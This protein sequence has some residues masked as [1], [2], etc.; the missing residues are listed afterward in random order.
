MTTDEKRKLI[1]AG[2]LMFLFLLLPKQLTDL[3]SAITN[4]LK[5]FLPPLE[6]FST[7]PYWDHK[8]WSWG[9]GTR[10]PGSTNDPAI[11]PGGTITREKAF[12]DM[13]KYLQND[14]M[15]LLPL[16]VPRLNAKQWTA[17]LSFSYNLGIGNAKNLLDNI[18]KQD[19]AALELQWKKY[20]YASGVINSTLVARRNKEWQLWIS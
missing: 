3:M 14:L 2:G 11:N 18:N 16:V 9:Y 13:L 6:G 8:Q 7:K 20:V 4:N 15:E 17:F 1:I 19:K 5:T 12:E 10:V